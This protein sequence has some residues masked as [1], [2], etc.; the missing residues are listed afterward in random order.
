MKLGGNGW[1]NWF[2]G[3]VTQLVTAQ[4]LKSVPIQE[5]LW[6]PTWLLQQ[7]A[8]RPGSGLIRALLSAPECPEAAFSTPPPLLANPGRS[9]APGSCFILWKQLQS[10]P[11]PVH[12]TFS[13]HR[14]TSFL[15]FSI[16]WDMLGAGAGPC[17]CRLLCCWGWF[18]LPFPFLG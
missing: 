14:H 7:L 3:C 2:D 16:A 13:C 9:S 10:P 15:G 11:L 18:F 6:T 4:L 5:G 8:F 17:N 1:Q 12:I